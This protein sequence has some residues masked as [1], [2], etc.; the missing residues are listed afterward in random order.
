LKV[1][2]VSHAFPPEHAAG[3]EAYTAQLGIELVRR[4]HDVHVFTTEKDIAR[5]HLSV[6]ERDY[7]GLAVH[8]VFNN[9]YYDG[10]RE[11]W[12][13]P[14]IERVFEEHLD[15]LR[16]DVVHFHHLLYLSVGCVEAA[17]RRG[18][19]VLFTLHDYWLQC[20][21]FG[22]RIHAD[23]T[24]CHTIDFER[25]GTCLVGFK[26]A[27]SPL[28]RRLGRAIAQLRKVT[29]YDAGALARDAASMWKA[30]SGP[31]APRP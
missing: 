1:L 20:A 10:F 11:T 28:E 8:E 13:Y 14:A 24:L 27:Q 29:G 30:R 12:D 4:G 6:R 3:T 2:L 9:L 15:A 31:P 5:P 23:G 18:I 25:C 16:P 17:A 19:P 22:Q 26:Y 21:R 7:T